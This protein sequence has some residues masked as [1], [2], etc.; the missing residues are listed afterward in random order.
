MKLSI[1]LF[2]LPWLAL[3][4]PR[5][6]SSSGLD[7]SAMNK[8]ADPCVDFYQYA[9]GGWIANNP[10]PGDRARWGRFA[11]L[12]DHNEKVLLDILQ[13]AAVV[14]EG[15][16]ALDRKIG[17]AYAACMDTATINK[18]G[19]APIK[20]ELDRIMAMRSKDDV[21]AELARL[22]RGGVGA[23]F[24]FGSRPDAKDSTRTI[25][26]LGQGG[27][28]LAD[29]EYYLKTDAKSVEIRQ[30]FVQ[31]MKNMF[32][33]AGDPADSAA[34]RAQMVLDLETIIAKDS[35][36]RVSNRDPNKTY[37]IMTL[38]ELAALAP[39]FPW[40]AY[41][42]GTGAPAF[43]TLNVSQPD[44]VKR[45][46]EDL[47]GQPIDAWRA[48]FA[49]HLL[50][51]AATELPE[52]FE[53][54]AFDFWTR[55]LT[56][57]QEQRPRSARCVATVDRTLGDLLGQK[58]I[59]LAFSADAKAQITQLVDALEKAM[60]EDIRSLPWMTEETKKA[61]IAKLQAITNNVGSPKKWRDYSKLVIERDDF[62][63]NSTRAAQAAYAQHIEKIG[64]PTDKTEWSMSTPTVNA[65]YSP[66]N[67]SIN[68]PAGILQPPFFDPRR[69][70]A[71]NYGGVGAVIGHEMTHGFD[72]QGRKFDGDGNLRDWWTAAD[73]AEF[74]KRAACIANE[75]SGF[76]AVDDVKLNGRLT[77]GENSAD[78]GGTRIALMA[79]KDTLK[80][81]EDR[82][83]GLTPE[84]RFFIGYGQIWCENTASQERRN[85]A[86]TDPHSP[87][88]YRVNGVLQNMPEFQQAFSCKAGQPMVSENACRVW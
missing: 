32:V 69:D 8:T 44:F 71:F 64:K 62:L 56:G 19:I 49:F 79:L 81:K 66:Q 21:V 41:F 1:L 43:K 87:G 38:A 72:D 39:N 4:Q 26:A 67:N 20:P 60:G 13:G 59:Q 73:G 52:S 40:E 85:R 12:S 68:F 17:D 55:Y 42:Q 23:L 51:S 30:R 27:L 65:F 54:E 88:R 3:A 37:H 11:E 77:L 74:E 70:K 15:S 57:A 58:Y 45:I 46:S 33:L 86:M 28:S 6:A 47:A 35:M 76:T 83:D 14:H 10:L 29:R 5:A 7:A 48:Y 36:D 50:R 80:G 75:Y 78:N 63:G 25:A 18:K 9:C 34:A 61:A 24:M 82:V 53:K 2:T 16:S 84:Q 31:H 22:H